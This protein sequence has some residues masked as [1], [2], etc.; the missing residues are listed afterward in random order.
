M[1]LGTR[2]ATVLGT[3]QQNVLQT[4]EARVLA[5][6][7]VVRGMVLTPVVRTGLTRRERTAS[8]PVVR[9]EPLL[10]AHTKTSPTPHTA[11]RA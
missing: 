5:A 1:V 11:S 9:T 6:R 7:V 2:A 8:G 4:L 10:Q 3:R